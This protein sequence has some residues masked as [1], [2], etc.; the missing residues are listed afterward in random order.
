MPNHIPIKWAYTHSIGYTS[1]TNKQR[2]VE[3]LK[4]KEKILD[5]FSFC[6]CHP[7][8][9]IIFIASILILLDVPEG[10]KNMHI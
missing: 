4:D 7:R 9:M 8:A 3:Q 10:T 5:H 6:A 2:L 1:V